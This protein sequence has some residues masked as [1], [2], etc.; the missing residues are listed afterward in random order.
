MIWRA[1]FATLV[2][3]PI[4]MVEGWATTIKEYKE[5]IR[6]DCEEET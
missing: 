3:I 6:G 4:L 1:I 2:F 5:Y